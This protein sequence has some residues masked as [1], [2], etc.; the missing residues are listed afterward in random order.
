MLLRVT[1]IAGLLV[2]VAPAGAQPE[3]RAPEIR[4]MLMDVFENTEHFEASLARQGIPARLRPAY[5]EHIALLR[6]DEMYLRDFSQVLEDRLP[7]LLELPLQ[8]GFDAAVMLSYAMVTERLAV[9]LTRLDPRERRA[10]F[11]AFLELSGDMPADDC[12]LMLGTTTSDADRMRLEFDAISRR[13]V[14][15]VAGYLHLSRSALRASWSGETWDPGRTGRGAGPGGRSLTVPEI[16]AQIETHLLAE[17]AKQGG[18]FAAV[19]VPLATPEDVCGFGLGMIEMILDAPGP[20]GDEMLQYV[21]L[22]ALE[23]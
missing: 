11:Q 12:A 2:A 23:G 14:A 22:M 3:I 6:T 19:N 7:D 16:E 10:V 4:S 13:D 8:E 5:L 1:L 17:L 20:L 18:I 21:A 15:W 9:G